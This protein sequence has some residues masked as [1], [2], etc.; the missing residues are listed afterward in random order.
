MTGALNANDIPR[1]ES[2]RLLTGRGRFIDTIVLPRMLH[3]A[4]LRSPVAHATLDEVDVTL[5][6]G[7]PGVV[8]AFNADDFA[9]LIAEMPQTKLA[10]LPDHISPPQPPL[11]SDTIRH[12]GE[13]IAVVAAEN[14]AL[15]F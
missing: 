14:L 5:A 6:R 11:V 1:T 15:H 4:F 12:Q 13:P 8:G 10:T 7:K 9:P 3:L 2:G